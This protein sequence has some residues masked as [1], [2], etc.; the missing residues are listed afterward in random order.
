MQLRG[1]LQDSFGRLVLAHRLLQL[2]QL[3]LHGLGEV[4]QI[5]RHFQRE[6]V[7]E[8][9]LHAGLHLLVFLLVLELA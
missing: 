8:Q 5:L 1:P 7:F 3:P 6:D 2:L 4:L 9:S